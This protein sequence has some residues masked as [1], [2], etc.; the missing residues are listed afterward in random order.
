MAMGVGERA[1][2]AEGLYLGCG[3][4]YSLER[5]GR[6]DRHGRWWVMGRKKITSGQLAGSVVRASICPCFL[7]C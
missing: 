5:W 3:P 1:E 2:A 6:D 7:L 4:R